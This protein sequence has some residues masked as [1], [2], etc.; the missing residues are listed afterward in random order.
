MELDHGDGLM[1]WGES[2][3]SLISLSPTPSDDEACLVIVLGLSFHL[4]Q[5]PSLSLSKGLWLRGK[6]V[7]KGGVCKRPVVFLVLDGFGRKAAFSGNHARRQLGDNDNYKIIRYCRL[8]DSTKLS[9]AS[10]RKHRLHRFLRCLASCCVLA[11]SWGCRFGLKL[12][13]TLWASV[14]LLL[15][16]SV[17]G[18][19]TMGGRARVLLGNP[20]TL[21]KAPFSLRVFFKGFLFFLEGLFQW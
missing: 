12:G 17:L 2:R 11:A 6:E 20:D 10:S 19:V 5:F 7:G 4:L 3:P 9:P 15:S 8:S 18:V 13:S 21:P 16:K 1:D 14:W